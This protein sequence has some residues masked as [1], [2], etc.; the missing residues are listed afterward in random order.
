MKD[1]MVSTAADSTSWR[2]PSWLDR[3]ARR[4]V[5]RQLERL[6][7]GRLTVAGP[8]GARTFGR[9]GDLSATITVTEPTAYRRLLT[10]GTLAAARSYVAGEWT[11][12]D[13]TAAC[14]VFA[15]N[16][17][18]ANG[19]ERGSARLSAPGLRL[20]QW[21][22]RNTKRGSRRNIEAHYDLGNDFFRLFLDDTMSYSCAIFEDEDTA[23]ADASRAKIDR[24]CR[25]LELRPSDHLL[26]IGTGWGELAIHAASRYGCRVTT[27]TISRQQRELAEQRIREAGLTDRIDVL[28]ADYRDLTDAYDKAVSVEMIEAVGAD[29]L[30]TFFQQC[31]NRLAPGGRMVIQAITVPDERYTE[32]LQSVDFIQ[33]DV[34]PGSCLVSL[35]AMNRS[36]ARTTVLQMGDVEDLTPHY[37]RTLREWRAR[38]LERLEDVRLLGYSEEFI[39]RWDFYLCSCEAGFAERTTGLVQVVFTRPDGPTKG[40]RS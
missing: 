8:F 19:L 21:M 16:M 2:Q 15:R 36:A 39:R 37:A 33:Q 28:L 30:D 11:A 32:Y 5:E 12:D 18:V 25:K 24:I 22:L 13:L 3:L 35:G 14:R 29:Y 7:H 6:R 1:T 4:V 38:F 20:A 40:H 34:F 9:S 26:E 23:L 10:G 31:G 27:T 17:D